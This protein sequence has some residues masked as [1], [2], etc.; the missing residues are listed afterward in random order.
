MCGCDC[1]KATDPTCFNQGASEPWRMWGCGCHCPSCIARVADGAYAVGRRDE[2][3]RREATWQGVLAST[4]QRARDDERRELWRLLEPV[5]TAFA[6]R[7]S[8][9]PV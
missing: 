3:Q 4:S 8:R 9:P 6:A 1:C 5:V 2:S 7:N